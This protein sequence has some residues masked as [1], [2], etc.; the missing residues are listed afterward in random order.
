MKRFKSILVA[1]DTRFDKHPIVEEAAE[2]ARH[3]QASIKIVDIVPPFSWFSRYATEEHEHLSELLRKEK[4]EKL[5]VLAESIRGKGIDV[6][7]KVLIGK[8]SD[9]IVKEVIRG[10][11]NL[12]I[13]IAKGK[14]SKRNGSFGHTATRLLRQCPCAV[15]L[16]APSSRPKFKHI[17]GCVDPASV[18]GVDTELNDKIFELSLSISKYHDGRFSILRAW[19]MDD[20]ALLGA[21]LQ[22]E[23]TA[24][25]A[26]DEER[27]HRNKLDTF[28]EQHESSSDADNVHLVKG[29]TEEAICA[30]VDASAVDLLVM[31]TVARKGMGGYFIGNTAEKILSQLECSLLALKPYGFKSSIKVS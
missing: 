20:E 4:S 11:N 1:T 7:S 27:H 28:L 19:H 15:W 18:E 12:V 26:E 16:V 21:R 2:I 24:Q 23:V 5:A 3:N 9:E 31:G 30:F 8:A 10:E 17:L 29:K 13:A 6:S 25:Y 22:L 14:N